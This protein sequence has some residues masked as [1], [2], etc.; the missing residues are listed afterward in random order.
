[1]GCCSSRN[2]LS[3][4]DKIIGIQEKALGVNQKPS[5]IEMTI[6][7]WIGSEGLTLP[8]LKKAAFALNIQIG[9]YTSP[10][11]PIVLLFNHFKTGDNYNVTE[12]ITFCVLLTP[13]QPDDKALIWFDILDTTLRSH[14]TYGQIREFLKLLFKFTFKLLPMLASGEG[15]MSLSSE[16]VEI[17]INTCL[18]SEETFL[19]IFSKKLCPQH[20]LDK[21]T[22]VDQLR[23]YSKLTY[24]DGI[25]QMLRECIKN[26]SI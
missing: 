19:D 23:V 11:D 17:Y 10:D 2:T 13:A 9:D 24:P 12:L 14:L 4:E 18:K 21:E 25:R 15:Q 20:T 6:K 3:M 22:F 26:N 7:K 8:R 1:M 16:S 5:Q